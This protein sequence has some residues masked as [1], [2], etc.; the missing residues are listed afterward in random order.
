MLVE[1]GSTIP[2]GYSVS[3]TSWENDGDHYSTIV[4]HGLTEIQGKFLVAVAKLFKSRHNG[5]RGKYFGNGDIT[6][7]AVERIVEIVTEDF[8]SNE[9]VLKLFNF[10][11][12]ADDVDKYEVVYFLQ[13]TLL[14]YPVEYDSDF[15]RVAETIKLYFLEEDFVVPELKLIE[16]KD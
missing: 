8:E 6:D 2:K 5:G 3:V 4:H 12:L 16:V 9:E 13:E 1:T 7:T 10:D 14:S 11:L 15:C